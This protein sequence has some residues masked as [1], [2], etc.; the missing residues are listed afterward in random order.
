MYD[1]AEA[2]YREEDSRTI[3]AVRETHVNSAMASADEE[4]QALV[5]SVRELERRLSDVL[6]PGEDSAE[7][8]AGEPRTPLVAL[9][10]R[11]TSHN[12]TVRMARQ[13]I[14]SILERLEL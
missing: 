10:E 1:Q 3:Q 7:K 11:L 5:E 14:S 4:A 6:R 13:H 12:S 2:Q 9:A 8:M